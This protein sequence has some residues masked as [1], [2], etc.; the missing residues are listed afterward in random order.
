MSGAD[1]ASRCLGKGLREGE[2]ERGRVL[3]MIGIRGGE[4]EGEAGGRSGDKGAAAE[5]QANEYANFSPHYS[6]GKGFGPSARRIPLSAAV[7]N[8][9]SIIFARWTRFLSLSVS[10][11]KQEWRARLRH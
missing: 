8:D 4:A 7:I 5:R 9:F 3:W 10:I 11:R 6:R 1:D 2:R